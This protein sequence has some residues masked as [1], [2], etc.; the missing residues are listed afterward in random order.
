[1]PFGPKKHF[2]GGGVI[3]FLQQYPEHFFALTGQP[4]SAGRKLLG[5]LG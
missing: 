4:N 1:V 3:A 5:D 2:R